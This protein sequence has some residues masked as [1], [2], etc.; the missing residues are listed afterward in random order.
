MIAPRRT[1]LP[2]FDAI[3]ARREL[4]AGLVAH[5]R[6]VGVTQGVVAERMGTTQ[7]SVARLES[8]A[9]DA[10]LSTLQ[11]YAAALDA[12]LAVGIAG[13]VDGVADR[14]TPTTRTEERDDGR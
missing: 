9:V 1:R 6:S 5:R 10:R 7:S 14:T 13:T 2:G 8:G 11:R 3:A 12:S 4:W